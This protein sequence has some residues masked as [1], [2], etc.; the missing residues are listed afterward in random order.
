[1][2]RKFRFGELQYLSKR[3]VHFELLFV[4][5]G[6]WWNSATPHSYIDGTIQK[7]D[8]TPTHFLKDRWDSTNFLK[9]DWIANY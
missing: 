7:T 5:N 4:N 9:N 8:G 1:M 3:V 6:E 2:G